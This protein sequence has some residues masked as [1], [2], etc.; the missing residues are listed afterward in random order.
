VTQSYFPV[1]RASSTISGVMGLPHSALK[2]SASLPHRLVT[3]CHL[4]EKAP[5]QKFA[6]LFPTRLRTAP[7]MTP[8]A[9]EVERNTLS[10]VKRSFFSFSFTAPCS[11]A[12]SFMRCPIMGV[13]IAWRI[14]G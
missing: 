13:A 11:V 12:Y 7:S 1:E 2:A 9:L 4:L 8:N 6:H 14:S 10:S 5:L 3:S